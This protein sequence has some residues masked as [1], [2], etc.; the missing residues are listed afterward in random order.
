M[1]AG[2]LHPDRGEIGHDQPH[3]LVLEGRAPEER[4][5]LHDGVADGGHQ[6]ARQH[7]HLLG[8]EGWRAGRRPKALTVAA[9]RAPTR[10]ST[11]GSLPP[12]SAR[13]MLA[14]PIV[15]CW[16]ASASR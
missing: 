16:R 15:I 4:L 6:G 10:P 11:E 7:E 2:L 12:C 13:P 14:K 5:L 1:P 3:D 9:T 8:R